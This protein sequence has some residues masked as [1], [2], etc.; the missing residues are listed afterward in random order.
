MKKGPSTNRC[1]AKVVIKSVAM[2]FCIK[3][4]SL[5]ACTT[6]QCNETAMVMCTVSVNVL[7]KAYRKATYY[8][9]CIRP[10]LAR[11]RLHWSMCRAHT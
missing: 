2:N 11:D 10:G 7:P 3:G 8:V 9:H 4:R 6:F 5:F 1:V